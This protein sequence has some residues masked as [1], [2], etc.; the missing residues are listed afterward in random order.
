MS[1][2]GEVNKDEKNFGHLQR[3]VVRAIEWGMKDLLKSL[4]LEDNPI[5]HMVVV[6]NPTMIHILA[7]V[8]LTRIGNRNFLNDWPKS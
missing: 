4:D 2:I 8:D 6:G 3:L 1:R 5:S 7:G